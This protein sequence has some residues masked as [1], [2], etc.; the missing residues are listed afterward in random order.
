[1]NGARWMVCLPDGGGNTCNTQ[2][3]LWQLTVTL[4]ATGHEAV[5][6]STGLPGPVNRQEIRHLYPRDLD[7]VIQ[8][9]R[10]I[11][12][13]ERY[14]QQLANGVPPSLI[15]ECTEPTCL[16]EYTLFARTVASNKDEE[17]R[18]AAE[19]QQ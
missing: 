3:E 13:H 19:S 7:A 17:A 6:I 18:R 5:Q 10:A 11:S 14:C 4:L 16:H 2:K 1:M 8:L 15:E 9:D 12:W